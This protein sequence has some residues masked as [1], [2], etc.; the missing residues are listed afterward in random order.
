[1][2]CT[3]EPKRIAS[4]NAKCSDLCYIRIGQSEHDGYVPDDMGIGGGDYI[5]FDLCLECGKIQ[6]KF[7]VITELENQEESKYYAGMWLKEIPEID[8][9]NENKIWEITKVNNNLNGFFA[10]PIKYNGVRISSGISKVFDF[11]EAD[12]KFEIME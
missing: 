3:C 5:N 8:T 11:T 10:K 4:I 9:S 12:Q 1:M 6:G 7:P 2:T